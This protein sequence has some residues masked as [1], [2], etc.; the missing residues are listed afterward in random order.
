[1]FFLFPQYLWAL[2]GLAIPIAIHLWSKKEGRTIKIGS[3][4]LLKESDS[5]QTSSIRIN[6]LWLLL[7]RI[8]ML[9]LL[10]L[11][12]A[13]PRL[14]QKVEK[15]SITYLIEPSLLKYED[16]IK[17]IDTLDAEKPLRL[18]EKGFPELDRDNLSIS[19]E[20][21]PNYWQLAKEMR[22]IQADSIVVFTN[23]FLSGIHGKRPTVQNNINWIFLDTAK[24]QKAPFTATNKEDSIRVTNVI[25]TSERLSFEVEN[26]PINDLDN[27]LNDSIYLQNDDPNFGIPLKEDKELFVEIFYSDELLETAVYIESGFKAIA[28]YLDKEIK[29]NKVQNK[30]S[31]E[32]KDTHA[33]VWLSQESFG[34]FEVPILS[35]RPDSLSN[36]LIKSGTLKNQWFLTEKLD[37]ENIIE[38]HL[39]ENLIEFLDLNQDLNVEIAKYDKRVLPRADFLPNEANLEIVKEEA[40]TSDISHWFWFVLIPVL[41]S[42]RFLSKFRKQ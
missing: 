15:E 2:L 23:A 5:K 18:L 27:R 3:V 14:K 20:Q 22:S 42:E 13:E 24:F 30:D 26:F 19:K 38:E 40:N 4:Q 6:E 39:A 32:L 33:V 25:N 7:L 16:V 8:L 36:Y 17:I 34:N 29:I 21:I 12:I 1:M 37:S 10:V 31:I 41:I 35:Y 11:I 28:K 9:C